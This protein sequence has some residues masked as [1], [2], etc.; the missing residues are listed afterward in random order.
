MKII[1]KIISI[2]NGILALVFFSVELYIPSCLLILLCVFGFI[3]ANKNIRLNPENKLTK[4]QKQPKKQIKTIRKDKV[5]QKSQG[6]Q[7]L[8]SIHLVLN[9]N[10]PDIVLSRLSFSR[11]I[12]INLVGFKKENKNSYSKF[13]TMNLEEYKTRYYDRLVDSLHVEYLFKPEEYIQLFDKLYLK[14][15]SEGLDRYVDIQIKEIKLLKTA[16]GKS[17]RLAKVKT[18]LKELINLPRKI[19]L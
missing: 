1:I 8:E 7:L 6:V 12:A 14:Y 16:K 9:S 19:L 13:I 3:Y 17:N 5:Y 10:N 2:I 11:D 18:Y 4:K 15:F